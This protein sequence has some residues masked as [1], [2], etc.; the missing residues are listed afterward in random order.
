MF[1]QKGQVTILALLIG[2]LG[3]TV[4]LSVASRSL[5]DLRQVTV[6]DQGTKALAAAEAGVQYA[7]NQL[8][9]SVVPNCDP[10]TSASVPN[11]T[12]SNISGV[13]YNICSGTNSYGV[14]SVIP[15]DDVVQV[16]L[17]GQQPNVK[18]LSVVWKNSNASVEII[19]VN[20][21]NNTGAISETRYLFNGTGTDANYLAKISGNNFAPSVP[22]S[23]NNCVRTSG[24]SLCADATFNGGSCA[25]SF[26]E[27]PYTGQPGQQSGDIY[28]RIKPLYG[29]TDVSVCV[30]PSGGSSGNLALAYYQITAIATS[31]GGVTR[32]IQ[33]TQASNYLPSIFD[34]VFYSGGSLLK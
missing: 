32:K 30:A 22:A 29:S 34:N 28:L 7:L 18:S 2:L 5:S 6:V 4:G 31:S 10:S 21:D 13:K 33:T 12:L 3:L 9:N 25:G 26:G 15:Q 24:S 14:Y 11:L 8:N 17:A 23:S 16:N 27:I 20:L 1:Y 19:K